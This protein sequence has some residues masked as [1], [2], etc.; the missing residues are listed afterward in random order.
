[1]KR[2]NFFKT[3]TQHEYRLKRFRNPEVKSPIHI[4]WRAFLFLLF[5]FGIIIGAPFALAFGPAF[6][7]NDVV[8]EGLTSVTPDE[9]RQIVDAQMQKKRFHLFPQKTRFYFKTDELAST[10]QD[11]FHFATLNV[12]VEGRTVHVVAEERIVEFVWVVSG[13]RYFLDLSGVIL[14]ELDDAQNAQIDARINE[15]PVEEPP[16]E[17]EILHPNM[18]IVYDQDSKEVAVGRKMVSETFVQG[19]IELDKGLRRAGIKPKSYELP[20]LNSSSVTVITD[21]PFE[22]LLLASGDIEEQLSR[23]QLIMNDYKDRLSDLSYID[24][25]FGDHVYL[26]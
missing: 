11:Q 16:A 1:M 9:V 4:P 8:I 22:L 17:G 26:K 24:L 3:A 13:K 10:L 21:Q 18:P 5:L 15:V 7:F 25:R 23:L 19:I 12:S 2:R 20:S 14:S 6:Q